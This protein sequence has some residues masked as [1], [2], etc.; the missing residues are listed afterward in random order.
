MQSLST[1]EI[2]QLQVEIRSPTL[3][4]MESTSS[5]PL[6]AFHRPDK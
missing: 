6:N 1:Q 2:I 3:V 4:G 5:Q